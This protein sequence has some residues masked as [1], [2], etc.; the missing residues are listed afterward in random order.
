M[1]ELDQKLVQVEHAA[2]AKALRCT[3]VCVFEKQEK[4]GQRERGAW[5]VRDRR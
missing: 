2:G 3:W 5:A 4:R 1:W